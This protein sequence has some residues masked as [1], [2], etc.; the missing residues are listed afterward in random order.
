MRR[1]NSLRS[2]LIRN[3]I[4]ISIV[5]IL[6][7]GGIGITTTVSYVR[8][9][10]EEKKTLLVRALSYE[11]D[12]YIN[13]GFAVLRHL[14]TSILPSDSGKN[15]QHHLNSTIQYFESF[16]SI[17]LIDTEGFIR[18]VTPYNPQ[19]VGNDES[20]QDYFAKELQPGEYLLSEPFIS[21]QLQSPTLAL[22]VPGITYTYVGFLDL[23]VLNDMVDKFRVGETGYPVIVDK[24]GYVL[25]HPKASFIEQRVNLRDRNVIRQAMLG[26]EGTFPFTDGEIAKLGTI[27]SH[28][29]TGWYLFISQDRKEAQ[30]PIRDI[31]YIFTTIFGV[32]GIIAVYLALENRRKLV[33]P[34]R[35]LMFS[36]QQISGGNYDI[37]LE[38]TN[39]NEI[40]SLILGFKQMI[41][42]V[43]RRERELYENRERYRDLIE[44]A[45]SIIMRW[46]KDLR[47]AFLNSYALQLFGYRKEELIG[48]DLIGTTHKEKDESGND[49]RTIL[50]DIL[51]QPIKYQTNENEIHTRTGERRWIQWSNKAIYDE[52]GDIQE[53]LSIGTDRTD[54]KKAEEKISASLHEKEILLKE[55]HHRVKNNMQIISSL[56]SLQAAK[57][58]DSRDLDLFRESQNRVHS[59]SLIHE[60][61]YESDNLA[62]I[63]FHDYM[64]E[65]ITYISDIYLDAEN[66]IIFTTDIRDIFL[67]IDKAIPCALITNEL[68]SNAVKYAFQGN[69]KRGKI[70]I[71]MEYDKEY[72]LTVRDSGKGLPGDF[73]LE[74]SAGLGYQLIIALIEQLQGTL[75]FDNNKGAVITVRFP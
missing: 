35:K 57:V 26:K 74:K 43:Q 72:V 64:Q 36:A 9:E 3:Y 17:E 38:Q 31:M 32:T 47:Y 11:L 66:E 67:G 59:M 71:L 21:P 69:P 42:A 55:I 68:L 73:N 44:H 18:Y 33:R 61:L 2:I 22:A 6:L 39:Y 50:L 16:S 14:G 28:E 45:G 53:I 29:E 12:E 13:T 70:S 25:S 40:N 48:K 63:N 4:I 34:I 75:H 7:F 10:L 15:I 54:Y 46:D 1:E 30:K 5:P 23:M 19:L 65:L 58:H 52:N 37:S 41:I 20:E 56:L 8:D 49:M 24:N 27:I 60:Q 62:E 51:T